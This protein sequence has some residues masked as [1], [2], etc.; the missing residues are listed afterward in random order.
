MA[1]FW[2]I[3]CME[4]DWPGLWRIW[5]KEQIVT[6]GW[7]PIARGELLGFWRVPSWSYTVN[8]LDRMNTGDQVVT[9]LPNSRIGRIG[10]VLEKRIREDQWE[11]VVPK[12]KKYPIGEMGRRILVRWDFTAGPPMGSGL[13]CAIPSESRIKLPR[14]LLAHRRTMIEIR[15]GHF[16]A[17][18]RVLEDAANWT[19]V[20][21]NH[22]AYEEAWLP[23]ERKN[24]EALSDYIAT[25]PEQLEP[26]LLPYPLAKV[27]EKITSGR[28]RLDVLLIDSTNTPVVIECKQDPADI[29]H[30]EQLAR[31]MKAVRK[32][33]KEKPR[34]ILVFAG[35]P[36][37]RNE[38]RQAAKKA[39]IAL[40]CYRLDVNFTP[41]RIG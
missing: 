26:G 21:G 30:I 32:L 36:N 41:C 4:K 23:A 33:L 27:R 35:S 9:R 6:V 24:E 10:T 25:Y 22:F 28:D 11:P 17:F 39:G 31:Y 14:S 12:S 29:S 19:P 13:G 38:V 18:K 5:E 2:S 3:Y 7:A 15:E 8:C 1:R 37:V 40:Y 20:S 34:G 16:K